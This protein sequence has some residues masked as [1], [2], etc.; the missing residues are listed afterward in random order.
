M[1]FWCQN[2]GKNI[3]A[4][5]ADR[6]DLVNHDAAGLTVARHLDQGKAKA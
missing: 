5:K 1:L 2:L 4:L 3:E 6:P